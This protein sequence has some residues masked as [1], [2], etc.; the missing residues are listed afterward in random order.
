MQ[1]GF[2]LVLEKFR[3]VFRKFEFWLVY[4]CVI[5][6]LSE[7]GCKLFA[8]FDQNQKSKNIKGFWGF[9]VLGLGFRD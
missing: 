7:T 6:A 4:A 9:G 5:L 3:R 8:S 2:Y 1:F